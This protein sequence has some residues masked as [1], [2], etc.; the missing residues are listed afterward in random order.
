MR[1]RY[2]DTA[3]RHRQCEYLDEDDLYFC[4]IPNLPGVWAT[5]ETMDQCVS[6]LHEV[7]EGWIELGIELGHTI[8]MIDGLELTATNVE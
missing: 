6:E 1:D 5:G 7:L 3:M 2:I 8:P 4:S